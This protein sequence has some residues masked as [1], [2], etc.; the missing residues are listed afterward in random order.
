MRQTS[1][2]FF[3]EHN[4]CPRSRIKCGAEKVELRYRTKPSR[5][6]VL[7][8]FSTGA[9]KQWIHRWPQRCRNCHRGCPGES[10]AINLHIRQK[11]DDERLPYAGKNPLQLPMGSREGSILSASPKTRTC[12]WRIEHLQSY[13]LANC[14]SLGLSWWPLQG[15]EAPILQVDH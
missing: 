2:N 4:H 9:P 14:S 13:F 3:P 12:Q 6:L 8:A 1:Q 10:T 5:Q 11:N 7:N 15:S